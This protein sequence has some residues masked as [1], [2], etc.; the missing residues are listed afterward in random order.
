MEKIKKIKMVA[1]KYFLCKI[2][3]HSDLP[4]VYFKSLCSTLYCNRGKRIE[5]QHMVDISKELNPSHLCITKD[6]RK[7]TFNFAKT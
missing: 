3:N 7:E 6:V 4:G 5:Q 2:V 1:E